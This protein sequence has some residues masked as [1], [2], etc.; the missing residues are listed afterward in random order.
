MIVMFAQEIGA[1]TVALLKL[2]RAMSNS[3][4]LAKKIVDSGDYLRSAIILI[5][6]QTDMTRQSDFIRGQ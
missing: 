4:L 2:D 6:V 3:K 5:I 1:G